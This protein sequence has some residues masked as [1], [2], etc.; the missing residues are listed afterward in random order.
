MTPAGRG[1]G[2]V[3]RFAE[4]ALA[5][6]DR[7]KEVD[8]ETTSASGEKHSVTIWIVVVDGVPYVRSVRAKKGRWFRE[9]MRAGEGWIVAA[10]QRVQVRPTLV[11]SED[12][13][14]RISDAIEAKYRSSP[15]SVRSM[16]RPD[17][18][19][20]TARLDPVS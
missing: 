18:L 11:T 17:T 13:N 19:P 20:T 8:I 6:M 7:E 4:A 12:E 10:K 2:S 16:L 9:L 3:P 14:A 5:A 1:D 15:A